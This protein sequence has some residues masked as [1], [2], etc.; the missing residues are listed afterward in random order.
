MLDLEKPAL[1]LARRSPMWA[2]EG[3]LADRLEAVAATSL[4]K[5]EQRA[6]L[7]ELIGENLSESNAILRGG[8]SRAREIILGIGK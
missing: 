2:T 7:R 4:P 3:T 1:A 5:R 6:A 8:P